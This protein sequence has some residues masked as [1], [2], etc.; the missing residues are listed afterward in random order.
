[1]KGKLAWGVGVIGEA[2]GSVWVRREGMTD[3]RC[4]CGGAACVSGRS[5]NKKIKEEKR[6]GKGRD[7][8]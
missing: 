4:G 2:K 5:E 8:E 1:M 7:G 3:E 6:A